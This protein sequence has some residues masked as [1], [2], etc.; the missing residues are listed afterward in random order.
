MRNEEI[1]NCCGN[2]FV[3]QMYLF[4]CVA[5]VPSKCTTNRARRG[6]LRARGGFP[7]LIPVKKKKKKKKKKKRERDRE[8]ER[9][10]EQASQREVHSEIQTDSH[11][12]SRVR[13]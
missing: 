2:R 10:R 12:R 4:L 6:G 9:A 5:C 8:R 3:S 11:T 13:T 1:G 7:L